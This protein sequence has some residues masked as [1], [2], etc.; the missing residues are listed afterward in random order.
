VHLEAV[1]NFLYIR[2]IKKCPYCAEEILDA[3]MVCKHCGRDLK[4]G[5]TVVVEKKKITLAGWGA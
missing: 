2:A 3:A 5:A 4:K 1:L